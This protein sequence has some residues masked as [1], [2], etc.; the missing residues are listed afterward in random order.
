[1]DKAR[2]MEVLN[3]STCLLTNGARTE[4]KMP[5]IPILLWGLLLSPLDPSAQHFQQVDCHFITVG[6]NPAQAEAHRQD[7]I[8]L[9]EQFPDAQKLYDGPSYKYV[10]S[11][12]GDEMTAL[13]IFGLGQ[14]LGLWDVLLPDQF[15]V[16]PT[17]IDEVAE[18]GL[19]VVTG[20]RSRMLD[21]LQV[22]VG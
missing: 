16:D 19:I 20:Y 3:D 10:A 17:L 14:T 2:L 4:R 15:G 5:G 1:V 6:V 21:A 22:A 7:F 8:D 11:I 12:V 13:R 9:L 18:L